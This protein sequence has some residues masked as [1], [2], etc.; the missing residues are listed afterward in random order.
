MKHAKKMILVTTD[1]NTTANT[2][3]I[4]SF[5]KEINNIFEN[6]S[7]NLNDRLELYKKAVDK[8]DSDYLINNSLEDE[9][10]NDQN[11][12]NENYYKLFD[13][14]NYSQEGSNNTTNNGPRNDEN[15]GTPNTSE[16][17]AVSQPSYR[18]RT[19]TE[20][21][22]LP[23]K[24]IN[25]N[26]DIDAEERIDDNK[27]E[28][29]NERGFFESD[30]YNNDNT[31][32]YLNDEYTS[33][34][35]IE[36]ME[37]IEHSLKRK[38]NNTHVTPV[39]KK[40]RYDIVAKRYND[41]TADDIHFK[42]RKIQH[43]YNMSKRKLEFDESA[44]NEI[45]NRHKKKVDHKNATFKQ[46]VINDEFANSYKN[47]DN[48]SK[49][50]LKRPINDANNHSDAD[51]NQK[52]LKENHSQRV[53]KRKADESNDDYDIQ[54]HRMKLEEIMRNNKRVGT[55]IYNDIPVKKIRLE[56]LQSE[57]VSNFKWTKYRMS[58]IQ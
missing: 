40:S 8:F 15:S 9:M 29:I 4:S 41:S 36:P 56:P 20:K 3:K 48:T 26:S 23:L 2:K 28:R 30:V 16:N 24:R 25:E 57:D 6:R 18:S 51:F 39:N 27:Y 45:S 38:S 35:N 46:E 43:D 31:M 11:K 52:R 10:E 21:V 58:N 37:Y 13:P 49:R 44:E 47:D 5:E 22:K 42:K 55:P 50:I 19:H 17:L 54:A 1:T 33:D 12:N 53:L 14:A 7:L 34:D 32:E